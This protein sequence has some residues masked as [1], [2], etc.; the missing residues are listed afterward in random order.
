MLKFSLLRQVRTGIGAPLAGLG[1]AARQHVEVKTG[2][3]GD[4]PCPGLSWRCPRLW[5]V[6]TH[7]LA[8]PCRPGL[9]CLSLQCRWACTKQHNTGFK[10][11]LKLLN[12]STKC[13]STAQGRKVTHQWPSDSQSNISLQWRVE[14]SRKRL[15][16]S[17]NNQVSNLAL[18]A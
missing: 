18:K 7:W 4:S 16:W 5:T 11:K 6:M 9:P 15:S 14:E 2:S 13:T 12:R 3:M 1:W 8:A 17:C 10:W